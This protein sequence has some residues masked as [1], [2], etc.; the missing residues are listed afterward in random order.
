MPAKG[1]HRRPKSQ[2]F[3]RSIAVAGTGGAALALPLMGAA[4]AHAMTPTA[5]VSSTPEKAATISSAT[6]PQKSATVSE[7]S[8]TTST[9]SVKTYSVKVGDWLAKIAERQHLSGG[10]QKLYSDNRQA[11]G[12]DPSLIHPGLKLTI[13]ERAVST[14]DAKPSTKSFTQSSAT[15]STR[16]SARSAT[17]S[18]G[19]ADAT[20]AQAAAPRAT[21][22]A[23]NTGYTL[24]VEGATIGTGYKVA[25]SMWSSGYH[26]GVDFVVPTGTTV[27]AIAAGTVVSAGWG[28]AY[29]N[30]V[31]V[32]HAD[33]RYSQ[34][35]HLSALS[36]STGQTVT[37][38]QQIGL[39][40]ATGNV[41]GPHLHFEIRTTPNYGSD[42][43]PV[44][45]L[46]AHGVAVG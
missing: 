39:S 41:T 27:K 23:T 45:Y 46:R 19:A 3:S 2:R 30:Q 13:G 14:D 18:S 32:Q 24:P 25:G 33:G 28:G 22:A 38:S 9:A 16:S 40:G 11:I 15:T 4:G 29:G 42:V 21:G 35:A 6:V 43:D 1:K 20:K 12:S 37:E 17:G 36:V 10:W 5:A 44:A 31:V 34:Y 8:A 7:K 26:T